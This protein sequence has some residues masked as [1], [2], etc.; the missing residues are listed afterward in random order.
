MNPLIRIVFLGIA[1]FCFALGVV[2]I[3]IP[4]LPTTPLVLLAAFLCARCSPRCHR[5][6]A[7]SKPYRA[8]VQPFK[9]AGGMPLKA[10]LR[11]LAVSYAV[12]ALS[13]VLVQKPFVWGILGCVAVFLLCLVC[14]RIPTVDATSKNDIADAIDR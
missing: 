13:A 5:W 10:K 3:F 6:I 1:W 8:Y 7:S 9:E 12:L 2:G 4:V 14:V 11:M